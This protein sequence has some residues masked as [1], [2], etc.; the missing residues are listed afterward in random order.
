MANNTQTISSIISSLDKKIIELEKR[1]TINVT[2]R[3]DEV[4]PYLKEVLAL[5]KDDQSGRKFDLTEDKTGSCSVSYSVGGESVSTGSNVLSYG[6]ELTISVAPSTGYTITSLKVNGKNFT[7]G[8]K[9]KVDTDI[10]V[11]VVATINT[12]NLTLTPA[13]HS[14]ITV[15]KGGTPV[16]AGTGVITYGD[17]LRVS[18]TADEGYLIASLQINGVDYVGDQ[19]ITVI[20]NVT[21]TTTVSQVTPE[22]TPSGN[23]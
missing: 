22:E 20:G 15:T 8:N 23:E 19:T 13:E 18:A 12:Y 7:S 9:I 16:S 5:A 14:T 11:T 17:E 21:V 6:D 2:M 3:I 4:V 10:T 1:D